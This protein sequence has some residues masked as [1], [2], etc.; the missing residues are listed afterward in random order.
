MSK[1]LQ[2]ILYEFSKQLVNSTR[3]GITCCFV[4]EIGKKKKH[5]IMGWMEGAE[6]TDKFTR[7][8]EPLDGGHCRKT[9]TDLV[10]TLCKPRIP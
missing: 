6:A 10:C 8:K 4:H 2:Y 9:V 3:A 7:A 1:D 5:V